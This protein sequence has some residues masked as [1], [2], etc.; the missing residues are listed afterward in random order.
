MEEMLLSKFTEIIKRALNLSDTIIKCDILSSEQR[1]DSVLK[2]NLLFSGN[3][4]DEKFLGA[5]AFVCVG[6]PHNFKKY[7]ETKISNPFELIVGE[8][9]QIDFDLII[10][11]DRYLSDNNDSLFLLIEVYKNAYQK[12]H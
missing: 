4:W 11:Y 2:C 10:P 6:D 12:E 9:I 8:N 1:F 3:K 7:G 5:N